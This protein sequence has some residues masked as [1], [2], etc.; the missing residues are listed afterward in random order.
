MVLK[1]YSIFDVKADSYN[2]PFFK[3]THG[4]ALRDFVDLVNNP[5]TVVSRHPED[6]KLCCIGSFDDSTGQVWP[7]ERPESLGFAT[8]YIRRK[9]TQS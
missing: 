2:A 8:E 1:A 6:F 5:E 9:E 4:Q 7:N 3:S